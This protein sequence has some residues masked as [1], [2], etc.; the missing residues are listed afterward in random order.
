MTRALGATPDQL[1]PG[2]SAAQVL[3]ALAGALLGLAGG[4]GLFTVANQ[5]GSIS[6]PPAWWLIIA[7]LGTVIAVAGLTSIPARIG[8]RLPVAEILQTD[9][10]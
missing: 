3:P 4:F 9:G 6:Q 8:A 2:L 7:V 10:A 5:G 1:A